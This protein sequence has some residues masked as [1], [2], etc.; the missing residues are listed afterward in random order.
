MQ[1]KDNETI[2]PPFMK[3]AII[4]LLSSIFFC[5][6]NEDKE[7]V[8]FISLPQTKLSA[9]SFKLPDG[10]MLDSLKR[11]HDSCMGFSFD[12][13]AMLIG[14]GDKFAIGSIVNRQSLQVVNTVSDLGL[15][16]SRLTSNFNVITNPC[17]E[18]RTLQFPLRS[19]LGDTFSLHLP[20]VDESLNKEINDAILASGD[21]EMQTGSWVYIDIKNA[22]QNV[23][24]TIQ[25]PT[26]LRYKENILDT[27][28]MILT[29]VESITDVSFVI[30]T[31]KELSKALQDLLHKKP[32]LSQSASQ[33]SLNLFYIDNHKFQIT[34]N[35]FFPVVGQF[36][37]TKLK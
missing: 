22:L 15:G 5:N 25:L 28:N 27:S 3:K 11:S 6:C 35:G 17:Y 14:T 13:N 16:Q 21:A 7:T 8:D 18:K 29:A 12:V 31:E 30:N 4:F 19:L 1:S 32:S 34:I 24:D 9:K 33:S 26:G 23:L 20:N 36:M 10:K 37:K 2:L